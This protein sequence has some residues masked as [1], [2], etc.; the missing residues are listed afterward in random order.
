MKLLRFFRCV[1]L[2]L[3]NSFV[4]N[5]KT[6]ININL[7]R[8]HQCTFAI[9][10]PAPAPLLMLWS[11]VRIYQSINQSLF[12]NAIT[13]KQPTKVWQAARTGNSPTKLTTLR[14]KDRQITV[15]IT[16]QK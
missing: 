7:F 9:Y 2:F 12:A 16:T 6:L 15:H 10:R 1:F 3:R 8:R 13:S 5:D 14:Q 4:L 11:P